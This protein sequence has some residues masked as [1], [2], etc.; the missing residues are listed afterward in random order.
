MWP[1]IR[2]DAYIVQCNPILLHHTGSS[3][4]LCRHIAVLLSVWRHLTNCR[5]FWRWQQLISSEERLQHCL[6]RSLWKYSETGVCCQNEDENNWGHKKKKI[7][8]HALHWILQKSTPGR[9]PRAAA[10]KVAYCVSC[11]SDFRRSVEAPWPP[12]V[13]HSITAEANQ[14]TVSKVWQLAAPHSG[15]L[16]FHYSPRQHAPAEWVVV[17]FSYAACLSVIFSDSTFIL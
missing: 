3:G 4:W 6:Q 8:N 17:L 5:N 15:R 1:N 9:F 12:L 7:K 14:A 16:H 11:R 13:S 2:N 10:I